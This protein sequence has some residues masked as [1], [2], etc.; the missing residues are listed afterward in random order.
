VINIKPDTTSTASYSSECAS[1]GG[2]LVGVSSERACAVPTRALPPDLRTFSQRQWGQW[3]FL[4]GGPVS[5]GVDLHG[6][7][8]RSLGFELGRRQSVVGNGY[9]LYQLR[10]LRRYPKR[11]AYCTGA[12]QILLSTRQAAVDLGCRPLEPTAPIST[13][14]RPPVQNIAQCFD[15]ANALDPP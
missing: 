1:I 14:V 6:F 9:T 12:V 2:R 3:R 10:I 11:T 15:R 13:R 4:R 7:F 5:R 8:N